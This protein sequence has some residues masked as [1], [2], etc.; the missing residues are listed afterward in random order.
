MARW[1]KCSV[2]TALAALITAGASTAS[3]PAPADALVGMHD[4]YVV[5]RGTV[6]LEFDADALASLGL[7][8][9]PHVE[10]KEA[11]EPYR[12]VFAVDAPSTLEIETVGSTL[13]GIIGGEART[14][15]A[16]LVDRPGGRTIV[17]NFV[18]Q[19]SPD[20]VCTMASALYDP[21]HPEVTFELTA[22]TVGFD[23]HAQRFSFVA[24]ACQEPTLSDASWPLHQKQPGEIAIGQHL[25]ET[26]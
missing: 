7:A 13:A 16:L 25:A 6:T 24:E 2:A 19:I 1:T 14:R 21:G 4:R 5:D 23:L 8:I 22:V 3:S 9:I 26:T 18:L 15:G 20:I 11:P 12:A 17:G 10:S